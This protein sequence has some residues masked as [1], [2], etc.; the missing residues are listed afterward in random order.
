M[1]NKDEIPSYCYIPNEAFDLS[2]VKTTDRKY[3]IRY[4]LHVKYPASDFER[5][6]RD[7]LST[8]GFVGLKYSLFNPEIPSAIIRDWGRH[9]REHNGKDYDYHTKL[10]QWVNQETGLVVI[11]KLFY[12]YPCDW[13]K[14]KETLNIEI[15]QTPL[16]GYFLDMF[17]QYRNLHVEEF[18]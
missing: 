5:T 3:G 14:D 2:C 17:E 7:E 13:A 15:D 18:R 16:E 10:T 1:V 11:T 8:N 12:C 9:V 6:L 4:Q